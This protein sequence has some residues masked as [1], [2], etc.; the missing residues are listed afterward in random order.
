MA[1][2][3]P[4]A[5]SEGVLFQR[6]IADVV[7]VEKRVVGYFKHLQLE[8]SQLKDNQHDLRMPI[9][10]LLQDVSTTWNSTFYMVEV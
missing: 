2:T 9:E 6:S 7:A 4:L 3:L 1:H 5:V 10:R 8:Y